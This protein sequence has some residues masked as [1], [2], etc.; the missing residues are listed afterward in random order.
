MPAVVAG[1]VAALRGLVVLCLLVLA[2]GCEPSD[3]PYVEV[4]GGGFQFNYRLSEATYTMVATS[5]RTIPEGTVFVAEFEDPAGG[6]PL[7][8]Q[9]VSTA[10]QKRIAIQSP[11]VRGVQEDVP[12]K[13]VLTL[14]A[15]DGSLIETHE[16]SYTSKIGSD[17]LPEQ[18]PTIGPGYTKNPAAR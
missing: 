5:R 8:V 4:S 18:P 1:A 6:E 17:V 9:A 15:P 2:A 7:R 13:V 12:Y 11:P 10:G 16:K 3:G 14:S